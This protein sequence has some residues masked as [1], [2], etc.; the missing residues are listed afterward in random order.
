MSPGAFTTD[1][2]NSLIE[3][4]CLRTSIPFLLALIFEPISE[5]VAKCHVCLAVIGRDWMKTRGGKGKCRL[6]RPQRISSALRIEVC[7]EARD[8]CSVLEGRPVVPRAAPLAD[9]A[10]RQISPRAPLYVG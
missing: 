6:E 2:S 7:A 9:S 5:H 4:Q 8:S 10:A 3:H 1:L